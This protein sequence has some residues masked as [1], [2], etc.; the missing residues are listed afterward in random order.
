MGIYEDGLDV[1]VMGEDTHVPAA[2]MP[3]YAP[4]LKLNPPKVEQAIRLMEMAYSVNEKSEALDKEKSLGMTNTL[5]AIGDKIALEAD[6]LRKMDRKEKL[7]VGEWEKVRALFFSALD[8]Y[9]G[10]NEGV[11]WKEKALSDFIQDL[12]KGIEDLPEKAKKAWGVGKWALA[13]GGGIAGLLLVSTI[14][15]KVRE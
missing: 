5:K 8:T 6:S 7:S 14:V 9:A 12:K 13:I 3:E 10:V 1:E 11:M 15:S 2:Q 4:L